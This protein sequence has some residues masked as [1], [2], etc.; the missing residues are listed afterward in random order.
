M[1]I[2]FLKCEVLKLKIKFSFSDSLHLKNTI[3]LLNSDG[4]SHLKKKCIACT[5]AT[6]NKAATRVS[7]GF[8]YWVAETNRNDSQH[9]DFTI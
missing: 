8:Q 5:K 4:G 2:F 1:G 6:T 7:H 9:Y 3:F